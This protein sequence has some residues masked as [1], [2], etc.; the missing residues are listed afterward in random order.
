MGRFFIRHCADGVLSFADNSNV[1][2][3][4]ATRVVDFTLRW[5][6]SASRNIDTIIASTI[7]PEWAMIHKPVFSSQAVGHQLYTKLRPHEPLGKLVLCPQ[8]CGALM[9]SQLNTKST[10]VKFTCT[11]CEAT[12]N[13]PNHKLRKMT[14]LDKR[15]LVKTIYPQELYPAEWKLLEQT[16]LPED[17]SH[18]GPSERPAADRAT[19][20]PIKRLPSRV[21]H[22][23]GETLSR[24][25]SPVVSHPSSQSVSHASSTSTSDP[26]A[27]STIAQSPSLPVLNPSRSRLTIRLPPSASSSPSTPITSTPLPVES[28]NPLPSVSLKRLGT[29]PRHLVDEPQRKKKKGGR[30]GLR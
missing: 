14:P 16:Q 3:E 26:L 10:T 28:P 22:Q 2:A 24:D 11:K 5:V 18:A 8:R 15:G 20:R 1:V 21:L 7:D 13:I 12:C 23:K 29:A 6:R 9:H 30:F 4:L 27:A 19:R 25:A 17:G